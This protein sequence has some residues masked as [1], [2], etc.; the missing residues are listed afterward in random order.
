MNGLRIAIASDHG[1]L[2]LRDEVAETI[3]Q[4]GHEVLVLGAELNTP[5]DDYPVFAKLVGDALAAGQAEKAVL[6]CGSGAG[7]TVAANKLAGV[8]AALAPDT[9]TGHQMVEHDFC[10]VLTLGARI[11]GAEPPVVLGQQPPGELAAS[12]FAFED[13]RLPELLFRYRARNYPETLAAEEREAW[14]AFRYQRLSGE[15]GFGG[16]DV[17]Q[18]NARLE[19]LA[20]DADPGAAA[21]LAD[22]QAW[23]DALQSCPIDK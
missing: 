19:V 4:A 3:R 6:I 13:A 23:G 2:P 18:F 9:Y 17:E 7:V 22:L 15:D 12:A 16:L 5:T 21:L 11:Q 14:E 1:G 20:A 10:N 8:R